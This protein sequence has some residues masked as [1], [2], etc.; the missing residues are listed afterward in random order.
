MLSLLNLCK[1]TEMRRE[2]VHIHQ[3]RVGPSKMD[4]IVLFLEEDILLKEKLEADE[5]RRKASQF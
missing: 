1:S 5:V 2:V 4:S 3:I